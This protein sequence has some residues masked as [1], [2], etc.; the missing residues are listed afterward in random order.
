MKSKFGA[1]YKLIFD[2]SS[3][4]FNE[5]MNNNLTSFVKT[6]IPSANR[7]EEDGDSTQITFILPYENVNL[8]GSF[9]AELD[10]VIIVIII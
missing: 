3:S 7:V 6:Y 9:F 10:K 4:D 5:Q 8:F 1:G 2:K